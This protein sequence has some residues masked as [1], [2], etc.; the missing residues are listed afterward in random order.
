MRDVLII[1]SFEKG[2]RKGWRARLQG[3]AA[4]QVLG[5]AKFR[6]STVP[7][8]PPPNLRGGGISQ[9]ELLL[10]N[11]CFRGSF[12]YSGALLTFSED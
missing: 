5:G 1:R 7:L 4:I 8:P 2:S 12:R 3:Y 6:P 10:N 11:F 9:Q